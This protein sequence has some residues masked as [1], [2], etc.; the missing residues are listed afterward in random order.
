MRREIFGFASYDL[1]NTIG[2]VAGVLCAVAM[3]LIAWRQQARA[4]TATVWPSYNPLVYLK[5]D[6]RCK[7]NPITCFLCLAGAYLALEQGVQLPG[8]LLNITIIQG[9]FR[10]FP[11]SAT[12]AGGVLLFIPVFLLLSLL[13]P[14]NGKPTRQLELMMPALALN[15]V[16]GRLACFLGDCCFGVPFRFGIIFP[17][18]S[19]ASQV[20]EYGTR[21]FPNRPLE[22][23]IMLL[24]FAAIIFLHF[25]GKRTL[26]IFPLVFGAT[27]LF[28]GFVSSNSQEPL[29][30]LFGVLYPTPFAHLLVFCIGLAF[31]LLCVKERKRARGVEDAAE[32]PF[33]DAEAID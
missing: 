1:F 15:Y 28:I 14:G 29:P 19:G 16:F 13:F 2:V 22:S 17:E 11:G 7:F 23:A 3:I 10:M 21:L 27:G 12:F 5:K 33:E 8:M 9:E 30:P 32:K 24:C 31:L 18:R 4:G 25:R 20:Y 26:P 6:E